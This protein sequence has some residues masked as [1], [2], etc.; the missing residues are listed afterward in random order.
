MTY[1]VN[2]YHKKFTTIFI[3]KLIELS[4]KIKISCFRVVI[5]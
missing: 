5:S 1:L 4:L 2:V 3:I